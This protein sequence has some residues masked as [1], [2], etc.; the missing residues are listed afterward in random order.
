MV[1]ELLGEELQR[2]FTG[3]MGYLFSRRAFRRFRKRVDYSEYGGAPLLGLG[4]VVIVCH[5]RSSA[6]ALRNAVAMAARFAESDVLQRLPREIAASTVG[7][8]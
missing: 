3:Q 5:G 1:E 4:G 8:S 2:T 6:K 7:R